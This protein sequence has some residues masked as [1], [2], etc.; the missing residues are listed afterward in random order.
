MDDV[1]RAI[2]LAGSVGALAPDAVLNVG[3]GRGVAVADLARLALAA[4]GRDLEVRTG[5][6]DRPAGTDVSALVADV[7]RAERDLDWRA[8]VTL[9]EGLSRTL[10]WMRAEEAGH[11]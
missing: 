5:A 11:R 8:E 2:L 7:A 6:A 1:A 9:E 4:A 3:S 10:A